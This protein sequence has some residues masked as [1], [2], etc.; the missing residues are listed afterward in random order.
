M[1]YVEDR[2]KTEEFLRLA[3]PL[4]A[5]Q[6]AAFHPASYTLCYEHVASV[7]AALSRI[8]EA[9]LQANEPL[10]E[11]DVYELHA[12]H[13]ITRDLELGLCVRGF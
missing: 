9:R 8:L 13:V 1:R 3:L 5:R 6:I 2:E 11:A 10:T 12:R 7:N 4:M